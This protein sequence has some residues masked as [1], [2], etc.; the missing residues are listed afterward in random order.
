[1]IQEIKIEGMSCSHCEKQVSELLS[2]LPQV[3][4]VRADA[5]KG[6]AFIEVKDPISFADIEDAVNQS[7]MYTVKP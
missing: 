3:E 6:I 5:S 4:S 7:G 1:M 2:K